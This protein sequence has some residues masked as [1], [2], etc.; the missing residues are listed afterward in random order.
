MGMAASSAAE[1]KDYH[2]NSTVWNSVHCVDCE[3]ELGYFPPHFDIGGLELE[4]YC[5][6]CKDKR[7]S[8]IEENCG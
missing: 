8:D 6:D 7:I 4:I 3:K 5:A 2:R 1:I